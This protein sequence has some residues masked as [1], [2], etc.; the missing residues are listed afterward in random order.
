M[1][2]WLRNRWFPWAVL[3]A[4]AA[5]A[6]PFGVGVWLTT[7]A[8]YARSEPS[9]YGIGWGCVLSPSDTG[10]VFGAL[11]GLAAVLLAAVLLLSEA[12]GPRATVVRSWVLLTV[13]VVAAVLGMTVLVASARSAGWAG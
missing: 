12:L 5:G 1:S 8:R 13:V 11:W 3:G 2:P 6:L 4:G 10:W 7:A 9:C